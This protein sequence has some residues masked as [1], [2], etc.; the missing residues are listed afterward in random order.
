MKIDHINVYRIILPFKRE[1]SISQW[2]AVSSDTIVVEILSGKG[3]IR[4]V[5]EGL[6]IPFVTGET[7]ESTL[8]HIRSFCRKKTFPWELEDVSQIWEYVDSL[9]DGKENS[10]AVSALEMSLLD[11]LGKKEN[12]AVIEYFPKD[13]FTESIHYGAIVP[14]GDV[15]RLKEVCELLKNMEIYTIRIKMGADLEQDKRA[16]ELVRTSLGDHCDIRID[17]NRIWDRQLVLDHLPLIREYNV[18]V[19]EEPMA[20]DDTGFNESV[21]L[22][23]STGAIIMACE[24]APTLKEVKQAV[25]KGCYQLIN[26]KL[27]RSGGFRRALQTIDFLRSSGVPFQ[28]GCSLGESGILSAAGRALCL[29][30]GDAVYYD[31]SYDPFLLAENT[32]MNDVSFGPGGEAGPLG[33]SGLGVNVDIKKL[34][35][36][37]RSEKVTITN[38]N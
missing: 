10:S 5:G 25:K 21:D 13:F 27:C 2:R 11:L 36:L 9:P 3:E 14:L 12:R 18:R 20:I 15:E 33:G 16:F 1:F 37:S 35:Q 38:P 17:P 22:I 4:G 34:E 28:V 23:R 29:L 30:C 32:T 7:P 19:V 26:V 31:G 6:P 8:D 24:S